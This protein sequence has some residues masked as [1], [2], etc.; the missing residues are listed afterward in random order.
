MTR[1]STTPSATPTHR[2]T[3][4]VRQLQLA[5]LLVLIVAVVLGCF[6]QIW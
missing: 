2:R 1:L 6:A 4:L 5:G 3:G